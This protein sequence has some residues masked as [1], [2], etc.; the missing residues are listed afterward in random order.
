LWLWLDVEPAELGEETLFGEAVFVFLT[1]LFADAVTAV[2]ATAFTFFTF[3]L[4]AAV[5][6]PCFAF[7]VFAAFFATLVVFAFAT[8]LAP[9]EVFAMASGAPASSKLATRKPDAATFA[10]F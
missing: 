10:N 3:F 1:F 9:T 8:V 6:T 7:G 2:G 5:T 4:A